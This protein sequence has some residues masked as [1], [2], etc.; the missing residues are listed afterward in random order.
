MQTTWKFE[1]KKLSD[2][3][4]LFNPSRFA[5]ASPTKEETPRRP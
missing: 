4:K 1:Q 2:V 5:H 3:T